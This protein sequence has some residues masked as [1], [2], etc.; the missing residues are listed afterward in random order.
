MNYGIMSI[1]LANNSIYSPILSVILLVSLHLSHSKYIYSDVRYTGVFLGRPLLAID[2]FLPH[3]TTIYHFDAVK[4]SCLFFLEIIIGFLMGVSRRY[5]LSSLGSDV[6]FFIDNIEHFE[7]GVFFYGWAMFNCALGSCQRG[8]KPEF[9][10]N[11][12]STN[13]VFPYSKKGL[14]VL[15][16]FFIVV[17]FYGGI[18]GIHLYHNK[19][20]HKLTF[21]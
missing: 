21:L 13:S 6:D 20:I 8:R 2:D 16:D 1:C 11:T 17:D 9:H 14:Y 19:I 7:Q 5:S 18:G 12:T 15:S 4:S 3:C 10:Q